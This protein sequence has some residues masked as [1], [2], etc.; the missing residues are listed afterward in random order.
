MTAS[1]QLIVFLQGV[2]LGDVSVSNGV[3]D[4]DSKKLSKVA[5]RNTGVGKF[6]EAGIIFGIVEMGSQRASSYLVQ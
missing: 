4:G 1:L 2:V 6:V 3:L 5:E